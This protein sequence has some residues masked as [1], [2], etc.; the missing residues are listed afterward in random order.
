MLDQLAELAVIGAGA[1]RTSLADVLQACEIVRRALGAEEAY[2]VQATDPHFTKLG[3]PEH[4][5]RELPSLEVRRNRTCSL[6][7]LSPMSAVGWR[8]GGRARGPRACR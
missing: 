3:H 2:V 8:G 7:D 1:G 6:L 4:G 5:A